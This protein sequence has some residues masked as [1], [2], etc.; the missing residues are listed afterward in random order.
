MDRGGDFDLSPG[1]LDRMMESAR[2]ASGFLKA[3]SNENRLMI[4]CLLAK[5][6][7]SVTELETVLALR[8]PTVS[9]Q[10]ARLRAEELVTTR[11]AGK[12]IY[13]ALASDEARRLMALLYEIFCGPESQPSRREMPGP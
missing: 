9:Q 8:Q 1:E 7:K 5:G 10:L 13:Y 4:L 2:A 11:R 12:T 3:L 6:E